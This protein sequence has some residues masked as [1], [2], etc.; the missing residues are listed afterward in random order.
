[1]THQ[2]YGKY[3]R[4]ED[5]IRL[6]I[7]KAILEVLGLADPAI[8]FQEAPQ[9]SFEIPITKAALQNSLEQVR[10]ALSL[11]QRHLDQAM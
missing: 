9:E 10:A 6:D 8:G 5:R 3:E 7:Y 2:Q 11:W 4:G 1:M